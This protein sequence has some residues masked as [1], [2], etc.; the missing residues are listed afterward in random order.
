VL[1]ENRFA[2]AKYRLEKARSCL[3]VAV[4]NMDAEEFP[5]AA[6]R[7]YYCIFHAMRAVLALDAFDSKRH[8]GVISEFRQ[9]Y[10]KTGV[11]PVEFSNIIG[12]A[13][14]SR[15]K[16]D[17]EDFFVISKA[18]VTEQIENARVFLDAVTQYLTGLEQQG[19]IGG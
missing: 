14:D 18:D 19:E 11:F 17:Y 4:L 16:S 9:K 12:D 10:I 8:S 5:S 13:F 2:Y 15:G 1:D 3:V 7:S 6:N